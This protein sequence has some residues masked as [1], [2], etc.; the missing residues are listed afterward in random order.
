M[1]LGMMDNKDHKKYI[2]Y[3]KGKINSLITINIPNQKNSVDRNK[4]KNK[5][6]NLGIVVSSKPSVQEAIKSIPLKENDTIIITGSLYLA[7]EILK[8]N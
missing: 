8:Q 7:A 5:I 4:L 1:I 2:N 3:F 6:K